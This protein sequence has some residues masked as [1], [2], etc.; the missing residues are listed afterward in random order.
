MTTVENGHEITRLSPECTFW[1]GGWPD[2]EPVRYPDL[3]WKMDPVLELWIDVETVPVT[4]RL[5]GVLDELTGT[6]VVHVV[7]QLLDEGYRDFFMQIEDLK[8]IPAG[9]STALRGME[10]VVRRAGGALRWAVGPSRHRARPSDHV[11]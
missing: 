10:R 5:A 9:M 2:T 11:D 7:E 8:P 3:A 6:S 1:A 4:I